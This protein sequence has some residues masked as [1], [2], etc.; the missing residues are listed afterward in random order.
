MTT[1]NLTKLLHGDDFFLYIF[2]FVLKSEK[3]IIFFF[4]PG[5][6][7]V[8]VYICEWGVFDNIRLKTYVIIFIL[9]MGIFILQNLLQLVNILVYFYPELTL[10]ISIYPLSPLSCLLPSPL[11]SP[12]LF[13]PLSPPNPSPI[14]S[15]LNASCSSQSSPLPPQLW[16]ADSIVLL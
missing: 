7:A 10:A 8:F 11:L 5:R 4:P 3:N 12:L 14:S 1:S 6:K 16:N 13:S 15:P 9:I 2:K